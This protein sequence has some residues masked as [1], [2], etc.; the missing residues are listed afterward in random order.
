[1]GGDFLLHLD[2]DA[3]QRPARSRIELTGTNLSLAQVPHEAGPPPY[4]GSLDLQVQAEGRGDSLHE[5][6][7]GV[8]GTLRARV[9]EGTVR[10]SLVELTGVDFRALSLTLAH[11]QSAEPVQCAAADFDAHDGIMQVRRLFIDS[12]TVFITGEGRVLLGPETLDLKLRGE[13]KGLRIL[14]FKAPVLVQGTLL[15]PKFSVDTAD[16]RLRLVDRGTPRD[17][18]ADLRECTL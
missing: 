7:A 17:A 8:D 6:A 3:N 11:N 10:A 9:V 12:E 16:S 1:M 2:V 15:Q 5:L 13:P 14:R 4:D 18:G